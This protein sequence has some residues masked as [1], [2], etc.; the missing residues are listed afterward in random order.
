MFGFLLVFSVGCSRL[1]VCLVCVFDV[2]FWIN[3]LV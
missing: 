1:V 3:V 2:V